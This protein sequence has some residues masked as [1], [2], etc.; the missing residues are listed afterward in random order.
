VALLQKREKKIRKEEEERE[1]R[2]I[3]ME[4]QERLR[5]LRE[6]VQRA[7]ALDG[8]PCRRAPPP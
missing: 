6:E 2:R 8:R 4:E 5:R 1:R 7:L 3:E